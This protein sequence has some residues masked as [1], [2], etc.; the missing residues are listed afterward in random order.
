MKKFIGAFLFAIIVVTI[1]VVQLNKENRQ[2]ERV[3]QTA[4]AFS[5]TDAREPAQMRPA[6]DESQDDVQPFESYQAQRAGEEDVEGNNS[7]HDNGYVPPQ[8]TS[9]A[10][11]EAERDRSIT[12]RNT[13]NIDLVPYQL[14]Y[15]PVDYRWF[16]EME[17]G[18]YDVAYRVLEAEGTRMIN[19][20]CATSVCVAE[21][22]VPPG[23]EFP[24]RAFMYASEEIDTFARDKLSVV[25]IDAGKDENYR[26][27]FQRKE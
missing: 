16:R 17:Q 1:M 25:F 21:F 14:Q 6:N 7:E 19:L 22:D 15:E 3:Q 18:L 11:V 10:E 27:I 26:I 4:S 20:E 2:Q 12:G 8:P 9:L 23:G 13:V 24:G 5:T